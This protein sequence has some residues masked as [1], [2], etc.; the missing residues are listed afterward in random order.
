MQTAVINIKTEPKIKREAQRIAR[1][2]GLSLSSIIKAYLR[3]FIRDKTVS[4]EIL[5]QKSR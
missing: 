3:Q 4:F 2:L 1:E 5:K